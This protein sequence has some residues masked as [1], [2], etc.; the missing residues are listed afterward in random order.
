MP[1][2]LRRRMAERLSWLARLVDVR[3]GEWRPLVQAF[4]T[5]LL[6]ITGHTALET[7][8]DG[9]VLTRLPSHQ[10]G[11]V[12][13]AVALCVLPAVGLASRAAVRVGPR[14]ALGGGLLTAALLLVT[15]FVLPTNGATAVAVY[16][17]SG[18]I[19]AVLVPLYWN[20]LASVFN[21][22]QA[23]RVLGIVGAAGV[24]GG[25]LGS[26]SAAT[27]LM[28]LRTKALLL[29][30]AGAFLVTLLT[31]VGVADGERGPAPG[32]MDVLPS[33]RNAT[34]L[35]K[36]PFLR[37]IALLVVASTAAALLLDYFFKWT[38][39]RTVPHDEI[40]R[41]VAR[42]YAWLN[43]LS[44]VAQVFVTGALV[45]RIGVATTMMVTPL[46]LLLGG[47]G[48]L[49]AAG[50]VAAVL[51]LKAVDGTLRNSVHRVTM[52]LVYLPVPPS[53]RART[54][55]FIDGALVRVTQA[56]AG[57]LLLGLGRA[58]YLSPWLLGGLVVAATGAWFA[59]A[60]TIRG[61]YLGLLQRAVT[62]Q[63]A[64]PSE[65]DPIDFESAEALVGLLAHED[66][67]LVLAAMNVLARRGRERLIPALIL[68]HEDE[69]VLLRALHIF[70]GSAREDWIARARRLL[71][72]PR[73]PVRA[74]AAGALAMH[75]RL[76]ANDLARDADPRLHAYAALYLSLAAPNRDPMDDPRI[77]EL[78]SQSGP[79]GDE[80]RLGLLTAIVDA[81]QD[82]RLSL[83]LA[84]LDTRAVASREW[85]E[86]LAKAAASQQASA[87]IAHLVSLLVVGDAREVVRAAL[88]S[89][90]RPAMDEVW[91]TLLDPLRERRLRAQ[92]PNTLARF[93]N[94]PAAELLLECIET[95]RDGLIRYKAIRGLGRIAA[96]QRVT[97][98]RVRVER[99]AYANLVEHFRLL[100]LRAPFARAPSPASAAVESGEPTLFLLVGLLEDK[101]RQSLE[102]AFRLLKIA[103]PRDDIH[104]VQIA[105]Q[106]ED[107]RAR[108]NAGE[109]LDALLR[110]RDQ[111]ALRELFLVVADNLSIADRAARGSA[112]LSTT[113]PASR[114]AAVT[115]MV[116]D[117]DTTL[118]ALA[119]LHA[120][121]VAGQAASVTISGRRGERAYVELHTVAAPPA[122]RVDEPHPHA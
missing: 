70:G 54:K 85:T 89:F 37:R 16:V 64:A 98:D 103:H 104:R 27:L 61:S 86:G 119:A 66:R 21:V 14:R 107:S 80:A 78:L 75:G 7:A 118:A 68:Q 122:V 12:Y 106:S 79:E 91:G 36:E 96:D 51:G 45:R 72:D 4:V 73:E 56:V 92:L 10:L 6:L 58:N 25:A 47:V 100:G 87:L 59:V 108:A 40:A 33:R 46:L 34:D 93:R 19:G 44:L 48:A 55:P 60:T 74:A 77:A 13:V 67:L 82:D 95:E 17:T 24:L 97:M 88:V 35:R 32:P 42:Y 1:G 50:A 52:E 116:G 105:S 22:A 90:G 39:A 110:G 38:V 69:G 71:T 57:L 111:R 8:R 109:F 9:L 43:G 49:A 65:L 3:R 18:L 20:L 115:L 112:L 101:L 114:E 28:V 83:L 121:A 62:G 94:K 120:A 84:A 15:L 2:S 11:V 29:V 53:V 26:A 41:F 76:D 81:K 63:E 23:R 117:A 113:L 5:L 31:L 102:R 30:S 99:I